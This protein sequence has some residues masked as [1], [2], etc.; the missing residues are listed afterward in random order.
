MF[1]KVAEK[2]DLGWHDMAWHNDKFNEL[3]EAIVGGSEQVV[4]KSKVSIIVEWGWRITVG[5]S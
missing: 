4:S 3:N 5:V 2:F 1:S